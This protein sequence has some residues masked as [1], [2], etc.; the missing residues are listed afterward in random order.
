M[1]AKLTLF[2]KDGHDIV[3]LNGVMRCKHCAA[4]FKGYPE[5][6]KPC[7]YVAAPYA[8]IREAG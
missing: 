2:T 4:P 1:S 3:I 7:E 5:S 8:T 6:M